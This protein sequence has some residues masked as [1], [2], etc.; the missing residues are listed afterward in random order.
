MSV[1]LLD[2][3]AFTQGSPIERARFCD[4]LRQTLATYGFVRL[5]GHNIHR[6]TIQE[7]FSQVISNKIFQW[8]EWTFLIEHVTFLGSLIF[9]SAP[10]YQI[11]SCP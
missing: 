11:Q 8:S 3:L 7:L 10:C 1:P 6:H 4:D 2:F 5:R 9:C